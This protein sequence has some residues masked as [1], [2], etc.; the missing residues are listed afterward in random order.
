MPHSFGKCWQ[1]APPIPKQ[2]FQNPSASSPSLFPTWSFQVFH[3]GHTGLFLVVSRNTCAL[4]LP[5]FSSY[6]PFVWKLLP[7]S[8]FP[9]GTW[10]CSP[11]ILF[12]DMSP[13]YL[14]PQDS[15]PSLKGHSTY[16]L[17]HSFAI[18]HQFLSCHIT[19]LLYYLL[20]RFITFQVFMLYFLNW[21]AISL[22]ARTFDLYHYFLGFTW[23]LIYK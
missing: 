12:S 17:G 3:S 6:R 4:L 1:K 2:S 15:L 10:T 11:S 7:L 9:S 19:V 5:G 20:H 23:Y 13:G 22:K 16:L 18:N 21:V 8:L 14:G